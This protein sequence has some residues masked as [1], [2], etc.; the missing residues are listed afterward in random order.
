MKNKISYIKLGICMILGAVIGMLSNLAISYS[1]ESMTE[2]TDEMGKLVDRTGLL[3]ESI[4]V[5]VTSAVIVGIYLHLRSLWKKERESE[6]ETADI[7]GEKFEHWVQAGIMLTNVT[8]GI[9]LI[10]GCIAVPENPIPSNGKEVMES[11]LMSGVMIAGS[12]FMAVMEIMFYHLMQKRDPQKKGDPASF[13]FNKKW[14]ESCDETEKLVIYQAGYK[15]FSSMQVILLVGIILSLM[16][17]MR[18][19]TG[20]FPLILAG[21]MWVAGTLSFGIWKMKGLK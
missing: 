21:G 20:N 15:A 19:D 4:L 11:L 17:K 2:F 9:I 12:G 6:D 18:F 16:G 8:V 5:L 7:C 13:R 10:L 3:I 14:L 1:G